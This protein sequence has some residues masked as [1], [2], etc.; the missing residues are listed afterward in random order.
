MVA[1]LWSKQL[2]NRVSLSQWC[3]KESIIEIKEHSTQTYFYHCI[4]VYLASLIAAHLAM[5]SSQ[6]RSADTY[7]GW[8][9]LSWKL[10]EGQVIV[11]KKNVSM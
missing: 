10:I 1:S 5:K 11:A 9:T 8:F 4:S 2:M 7:V 6:A 3:I